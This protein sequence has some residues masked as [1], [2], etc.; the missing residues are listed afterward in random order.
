LDHRAGAIDQPQIDASLAVAQKNTAAF[1][2]ATTR[3]ISPPSI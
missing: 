2:D 1:D 3:L